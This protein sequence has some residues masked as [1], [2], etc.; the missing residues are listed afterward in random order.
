MKP[1]K[2]V[3]AN[4]ERSDIKKTQNRPLMSLTANTDRI[5]HSSS[6]T[7]AN[8][9][10][11]IIGPSTP[12]KP[13]ASRLRSERRDDSDKNYNETVALNEDVNVLFGDKKANDT[14]SVS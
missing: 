6:Y 3:E 5:Q 9:A 13:A 14:R 8:T 7:I 2:N 10:A 12:S 1:L 11:H 4:T